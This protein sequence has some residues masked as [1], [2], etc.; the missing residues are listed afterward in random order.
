[1]K[2]IVGSVAVAGAL[3]FAL[4]GCGGSDKDGESAGAKVT[5]TIAAVDPARVRAQDRAAQADLRD[6]I[7]AQMTHYTDAQE[8]TAD[9]A[10]LAAIEPSLDWGGAIKV[11][12]GGEYNGIANGVTCVSTTSKSGA[13]FALGYV[14]YGPD[15]GDY[16][17]ERCPTETTAEAVAA[18]GDSWTSEPD[19]DDGGARSPDQAAQADLRNALVA[20]KV[21][22]ADSMRYTDDVAALKNVE[23]SLDWGGA[24]TVA[25]DAERHVVCMSTTS[26]SGAVFAL[27]DISTG[28]D[29]GVY[30]GTEA[31]PR[32]VTAE[33]IRE[34]ELAQ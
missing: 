30:Y 26:A 8:Y 6:A 20:Q 23:P 2:H 7:T 13:E 31:C 18:L 16:Y 24:L 4:A 34:M 32:T 11:A 17:G 22:F 5:T 9:L 14:M 29:A 27:G 15:G 19:P 25:V 10:T 33:T 28:P 1:M 12:V 3:A 21:L